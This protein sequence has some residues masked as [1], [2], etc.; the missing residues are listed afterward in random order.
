MLVALIMVLASMH[1]IGPS[2]STMDGDGHSAAVQKLAEYIQGGCWWPYDLSQG[3]GFDKYPGYAALII[4]PAAVAT[5]IAEMCGWHASAWFWT[6]LILVGSIP[7]VWITGYLWAASWNLSIRTTTWAM[8]AWTVAANGDITLGLGGNPGIGL[9]G[10]APA[11]ACWLVTWMRRSTS[12]TTSSAAWIGLGSG[13]LWFIHPMTALLGM[14]MGYVMRSIMQ[15]H[16]PWRLC[17]ISGTIAVCIGLPA[18]WLASHAQQTSFPSFDP[19]IDLWTTNPWRSIWIIPCGLIAGACIWKAWHER[20]IPSL[21]ICL[22]A[23]LAVGSWM[24]GLY[25]GHAYRT[26]GIIAVPWLIMAA[27]HAWKWRHGSGILI[28]SGICLLAQGVNL[29]HIE[30]ATSPISLSGRWIVAP[31]G[32]DV[33]RHRI[34]YMVQK[35]GGSVVP[36]LQYLLSSQAAMIS[37]AI[38]TLSHPHAPPELWDAI[39]HLRIRGIITSATE[40]TPVWKG[41]RAAV[42]TKTDHLHMTD[43][44]NDDQD[45][46]PLSGYLAY[47]QM[48]GSRNAI[49]DHWLEQRSFHDGM[50]VH[51]I[52]ASMASSPSLHMLSEKGWAMARHDA[53]QSVVAASHPAQP[54]SRAHLTSS[55]SSWILSGTTPGAWY[56]L[57]WG[58]SRFMSVI[59]GDVSETM[60]G[61][62]VVRPHGPS[63]TIQWNP[64]SAT[65]WMWIISVATCIASISMLFFRKD[66][67]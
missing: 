28:A 48:D 4:Y 14:P 10:Q 24:T 47:A 65:W 16:M 20:H 31:I 43:W 61:V 49:I 23:C 45:I 51:V 25:G 19:W 34:Q 3:A 57:P 18:A 44:G 15:D 52:S 54:G 53:F 42:I 63:V 32:G 46:K 13:L 59:G 29:K 9:I 1:V 62:M 8:A 17:I 56:P 67:T 7:L 22:S 41:D 36:G 37:G 12:S 64:W 2:L 50:A 35:D 58:S 39:D 55:G 60:F 38:P 40:S 26:W 33:L 30:W 11:M 6:Q 27:H 21:L 66:R 5:T